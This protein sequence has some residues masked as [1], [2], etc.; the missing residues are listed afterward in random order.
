MYE[1]RE[2]G[3][4]D[5]SDPDHRFNK[6]DDLRAVGVGI[7]IKRDNVIH[8]NLKKPGIDCEGKDDREED[9]SYVEFHD[10][11]LAG[12]KFQ[13]V[14]L[15][16]MTAKKTDFSGG[17][18]AGVEMM[19]A[20]LDDVNLKNAD[21]TGA[22]MHFAKIS[23]TNLEGTQMAGASLYGA[24]LQGTK[25]NPINLRG[26]DLSRADLRDAT[27]ENCD[28]SG[29]NL[30]GV[31]LSETKLINCNLTDVIVDAKTRL[32][33][34]ELKWADQDKFAKEEAAIGNRF[35]GITSCTEFVSQL[36]DEQRALH[37]VL[38]GRQEPKEAGLNPTWLT[39][40]QRGRNARSAAIEYD[41][42]QNDRSILRY[43]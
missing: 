5:Y 17:D 22:N 37:N 24:K 30:S 23:G 29:A 7:L 34:P 36:S 26:A 28:L 32:V 1:A 35:S 39:Q 31:N 8:K 14:T 6:T 25:S 12:G 19:N 11:N 18:F 27:L 2:K 4:L 41:A 21:L 42:P 13:R 10:C 38:T 3:V 40:R 9:L 15:Y 33:N 16:G 20:K 43:I